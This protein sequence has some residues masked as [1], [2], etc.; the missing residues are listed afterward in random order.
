MFPYTGDDHFPYKWSFTVT[1]TF[2]T[3][4]LTYNYRSNK[5]SLN[6]QLNTFQL[7][8]FLLFLRDAQ[9]LEPKITITCLCK[10]ISETSCSRR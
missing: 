6:E 9:N 7:L 3:V 5:A 8:K 1:K 2:K 4:A 10:H